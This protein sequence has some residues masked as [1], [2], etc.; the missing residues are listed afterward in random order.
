VAIFGAIM[1]CWC[2]MGLYCFFAAMVRFRC[3]PDKKGDGMPD[4][5]TAVIGPAPTVFIS[6]AWESDDFRTRVRALRDW[7]RA[8]GVAVVSDFDHAIR[9]PKIGWPTWMQHSI[10]D[11]C[12]VLVVCSPKYRKRFEKR[13]P[14]DSG[15]GVA[16]EGAVITQDLYNAAQRNEKVYPIFIDPANW[17]DLPKALAAWSNGH[18]FPSR[19]DDILALV[20]ECLAD[21]TAHGIAA[22][23]GSAT[24]AATP[25]VLPVTPPAVPVAPPP[26][27]PERI[28]QTRQAI[29]ACLHQD[30]FDG[31]PTLKFAPDHLPQL[32]FDA[33]AGQPG[34]MVRT[35]VS[36]RAMYAVLKFARTV[37]GALADLPANA[38]A[39]APTRKGQYWK[40]LV[41]A[42]QH[43]I[44]LSARQ[45]Y[46]ASRR[47]ADAFNADQP[48]TV[49][50]M[51][52]LSASVIMRHDLGS[53]LRS[54]PAYPGPDPLNTDPL[55]D[56]HASDWG[57]V[58]FGTGEGAKLE[59]YKAAQYWLDRG[60]FP[61]QPTQRQIEE[62]QGKLKLRKMVDETPLLLMNQSGGNF[63][64]EFIRWLNIKMHIGHI[65]ILA[66]NGE[67]ELTEGDWRA[68]L[69]ELLAL[70]R[71]FEPDP[72]RPGA[73]K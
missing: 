47:I 57:E 43:A 44:L 13:A 50:G 6:Y 22:D 71:A 58:E 53:S 12:V 56:S 14:T 59:A 60:K 66:R 72:I 2:G 29:L 38:P 27:D 21:A 19:Q 10:E 32:L 39:A 18:C 25:A 70:M 64:P 16:W 51:S 11:A 3:Q 48:C 7:L 61:A 20:R 35:A 24:V 46:T 40:A 54:N 4:T 33:F 65:T 5:N 23:A 42:M 15:K 67:F 1:Q 31:I 34:S 73:R 63:S 62:L 37:L 9:A 55:E 28:K 30:R 68:C 69:V 45:N 52:W 36:E 26:D 8:Q 41:N 49:E 17:D